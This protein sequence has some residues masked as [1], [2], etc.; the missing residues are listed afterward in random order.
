MEKTNG[1]SIS[2]TPSTPN[3]D[4]RGGKSRYKTTGI[5]QNW[6]AWGAG[7]PDERVLVGQSNNK[8]GHYHPP[9]RTGQ[10]LLKHCVYGGRERG[11]MKFKK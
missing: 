1:N 6:G 8:A 9:V 10:H 7:R 4:F 5:L 11:D 3:L 2:S